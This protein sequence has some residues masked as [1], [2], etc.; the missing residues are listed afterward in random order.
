MFGA[1]SPPWE[2]AKTS[3]SMPTRRWHGSTGSRSPPACAARRS[4]SLR[5]TIY[6][7]RPANWGRSA[8]RPRLRKKR[9]DVAVAFADLT[10]ELTD[11]RRQLLQRVLGSGLYEL[12]FVG[13]LDEA[14]LGAV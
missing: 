8:G 13:E 14:G 1:G 10:R 6:A 2:R 11:L 9:L 12:G 4:S 5:R 7:P 3:P